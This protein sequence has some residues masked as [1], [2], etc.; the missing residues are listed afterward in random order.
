MSVAAGGGP[1]GLLRRDIRWSAIAAPV[2]RH[3]VGFL[4]GLGVALRVAQYLSGRPLWLDEGALSSNIVGKSFAG[5]FGPLENSQLAPPGFLA[6]EWVAGRLPGDDRWTLRVVPLLAG[7][8]SLFVFERFSRRYLNPTAALVALAMFVLSDG[9]IY[10]S[11]EVKQYSSDVAIGLAC[12]LMGPALASGPATP[13]R[14]LGLAAAG[15][16]AVWFSHPALFVLAGVGVVAFAPAIARREW[17]RGAGLALVGAAWLASFAGVYA[18]SLRQL[19][20]SDGMWRFWAGAFPSSPGSAG[21]TLGWA[22]R[23]AL[24]LFVNP[25]DFATPLGP[26]A[27]ALPALALFAI[28]CAS[29]GRRDGRGL[30]TLLL[31]VGF[32]VAAAAL[33]MY[34]THGR[35]AL[36]LVPFLLVPI[37]EGA[38]WLRSRGVPGVAWVT[39]LAALLLFPAVDAAYHV[40]EPRTHGDFN[41][42]GD[43]RPASLDPA[44]FPL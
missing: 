23:K 22:G 19:G 3:P 27:S 41:P 34:P 10:Y 20:G 29:L 42:Y 35:L 18:V 26:L 38:G 5:L 43:R 9:L 44:R 33:R 28:G 16:G 36:F 6:L 21:G 39:V 25:L 40:V 30:A 14:L 17:G 15:A 2:A 7:I 37:A 8:A 4:L 12:G 1:P 31:P 13:R 24:Y 32:A 11:S